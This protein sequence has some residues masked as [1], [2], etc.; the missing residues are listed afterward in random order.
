MNDIESADAYHDELPRAKLGS[1]TSQKSPES[2][3]TVIQFVQSRVCLGSPPDHQAAHLVGPLSE[4]KQTISVGKLTF[5]PGLPELRVE[6]MGWM[7]PA[8]GI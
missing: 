5:A 1:S 6:Q 4:V 2:R 7:A 3:A 8:P